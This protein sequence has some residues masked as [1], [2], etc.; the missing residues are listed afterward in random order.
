MKSGKEVRERLKQASF[1][2]LKKILKR[3]LKETAVNC[4]HREVLD[5]DEG[6]IGVCGIRGETGISVCDAR[7]EGCDHAATCDWF[8]LVEDKDAIK[9][10]WEDMLAGDPGEIAALGYSDLAA[11]R[12]VLGDES[13]DPE[14]DPLSEDPPPDLHEDSETTVPQSKGLWGFLFRG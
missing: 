2:H 3:R 5:Y 11:L 13:E 14:I 4:A 10:A 1:Y 12:W 8:V 6:R 7:V 9:E